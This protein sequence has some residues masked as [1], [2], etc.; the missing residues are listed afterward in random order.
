VRYERHRLK[1]RRVRETR[2]F[3][4]RVGGWRTG[5]ELAAHLGWRPELISELIF[6]KTNNLIAG[7]SRF[8]GGWPRHGSS[9]DDPGYHALS[10]SAHSQDHLGARRV[11]VKKK[12]RAI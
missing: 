3:Y 4:Q 10:G 7:E 8:P 9:D 1:Q 6:R 12:K 11:G 5:A 2:A